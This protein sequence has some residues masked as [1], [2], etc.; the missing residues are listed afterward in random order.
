MK[1]GGG[2][3]MRPGM[4]AFKKQGF[5]PVICITDGY[6]P[7]PG[8]DPGYHMIWCIAPGGTD[9]RFGASEKAGW[10]NIV[11]ID[12]KKWWSTKMA[13]RSV[14]V[15]RLDSTTGKRARY[16]PEPEPFRP[17]EL[18]SASARWSSSPCE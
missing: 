4:E 1:G 10:S 2:T 11:H 13:P 8:G 9:E 18:P 6:I 7:D 16:E 5:E 12:A 17:P 3:D 14:T 15:I